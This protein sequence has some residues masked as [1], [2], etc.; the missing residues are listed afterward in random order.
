MKRIKKEN[1]TNVFP[2][3][4]KSSNTFSPKKKAHSQEKTSGLV[5]H[6]SSGPTVLGAICAENSV[7]QDKGGQ[8]RRVRKRGFKKVNEEEEGYHVH[9]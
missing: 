8:P 6:I 7:P 9:R 1:G 5:H 2:Q 3:R 4:E